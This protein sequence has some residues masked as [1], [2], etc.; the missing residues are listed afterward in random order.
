MF[1]KAFTYRIKVPENFYPSE[2]STNF[3]SF[4]LAQNLRRVFDA[5]NVSR[6]T[7]LEREERREKS[8]E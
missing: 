3:P 8:P 2:F 6:K 1:K 7:K 5:V 4:S